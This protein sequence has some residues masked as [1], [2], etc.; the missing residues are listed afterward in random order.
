MLRNVGERI[1]RIVRKGVDMGVVRACSDYDALTKVAAEIGLEPSMIT[2]TYRLPLPGSLSP[3]FA[4]EHRR[5]TLLR[6]RALPYG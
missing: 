1:F 2:G 4:V 3:I 6:G 5:I